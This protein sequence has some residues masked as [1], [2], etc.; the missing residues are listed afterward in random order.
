MF[1]KFN[2]SELFPV[3]NYAEFFQG[4]GEKAQT[5]LQVLIKSEDI[6]DFRTFA[7]ETKQANEFSFFANTASETPLL[8]VTGVKIN[9]VVRSYSKNLESEN[10]RFSVMV[11]AIYL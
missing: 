1:I 3:E 11:H 10:Q 5:E 9:S 4:E 7:L 8:T 2:S 6:A